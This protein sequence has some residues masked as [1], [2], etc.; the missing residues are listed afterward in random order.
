MV[1]LITFSEVFVCVHV[2][3]VKRDSGR[4]QVRSILVTRQIHALRPLWQHADWLAR[5]TA[6]W[7]SCG[8]HAL[9]S[10]TSVVLSVL[11]EGLLQIWMRRR[12]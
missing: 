12:I 11:G 4:V 10:A 6:L 9:Q 1:I 3:R 8:V 7:I 2:G 5:T